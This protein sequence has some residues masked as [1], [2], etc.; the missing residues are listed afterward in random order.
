M[1]AD[2]ALAGTYV[3]HPFCRQTGSSG[4]VD[5]HRNSVREIQRSEHAFKHVNIL[6]FDRHRV[7]KTRKDG[8]DWTVE[9]LLQIKEE[10]LSRRVSLRSLSLDP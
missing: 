1:A 8:H 2:F 9:M 5:H 10:L 6:I 3:D 7:M 4:R